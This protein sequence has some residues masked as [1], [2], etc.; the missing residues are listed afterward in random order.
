MSQNSSNSRLQPWRL[1]IIAL[2][3]ASILVFVL[4]EG[5]G[6][7][8]D[9]MAVVFGLLVCS[10]MIGLA[11]E[12]W[13]AI[14]LRDA[15]VAEIWRPFSREFRI[16]FIYCIPTLLAGLGSTLWWLKWVSVGAACTLGIRVALLLRHPSSMPSE[17]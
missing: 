14:R 2:V 17:S 1:S 10:Q 3:Y 5:F 6:A 7:V 15:A 16:A 13:L 11:I 8:S 4:G 9:I 12:A